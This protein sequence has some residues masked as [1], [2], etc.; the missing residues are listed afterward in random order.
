VKKQNDLKEAKN[1]SKKG[2]NGGTMNGETGMDSEDMPAVEMDSEDM[3]NV[4]SM[5]SEDIDVL[6]KKKGGKRARR[7]R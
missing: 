4:E 7:Q 3:P 6:L 2:G 5:D 1:E